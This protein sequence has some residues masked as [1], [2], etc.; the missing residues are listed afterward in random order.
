[1]VAR[2]QAKTTQAGLQDRLSA[3]QCSFSALN[4]VDGGPF[5]YVFSN[6]G[7]LNCTNDLDQVVQGVKP[8][9]VPGAT[10]T[11]V[12]MPPICLWEL[13]RLFHGDLGAG[14]RRLSRNGVM[15]HVEGI[16]FKTYY[17]PPAA[18]QRALGK[19]FS[20][21]ALQGLSV[22]TPT[23]DEKSFPNRYVRIY[24]WL[25]RLDDRLADLP[26]FNRWGDF[27]ILSMIYLPTVNER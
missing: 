6:M 14:L 16:Y 24:R 20:P 9:L 21:L 26:P 1:M 10:I 4:E 7:G 11:W 25:R 2:I 17:Y 15:A 8:L 27:Y 5:D 22:F 13:A 18:V 19:E 23:A 12:I 3:Q